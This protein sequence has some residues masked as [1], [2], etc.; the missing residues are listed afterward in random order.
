MKIY[1]IQSTFVNYQKNAFKGYVNGNYYEDKIIDLAQKA[2]KNKNWEKEM[3]ANKVNFL[4]N[5]LTAVEDDVP[6]RIWAAIVS[7]GGTEAVIASLCA[8]ET[9]SDKTEETISSV[10]NCMIDLLKSK[11]KK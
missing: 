10:K 4:K 8:A 5:Y 6:L 11:N 9:I 3:K 2:L 1:P 7:F